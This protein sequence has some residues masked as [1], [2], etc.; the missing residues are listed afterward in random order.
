M[1]SIFFVLIF[2]LHVSFAKLVNIVRYA[3]YITKFLSEETSSVYGFVFHSSGYFFEK[4]L[5]QCKAKN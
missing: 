3:Y 4:L 2:I 5:I 1:T